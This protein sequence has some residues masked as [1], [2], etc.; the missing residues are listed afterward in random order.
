MGYLN[1][2]LKTDAAKAMLE[3]P[4]EDLARI[5]ALMR[6]LR[7]QAGKNAEKAWASRKGLIAAYW[8]ATSTYARHIAHVCSKARA[9]KR[10]QRPPG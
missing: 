10:A 7:A 8:R 9:A 5:E 2:L 4:E 3:L 6:E 1:P